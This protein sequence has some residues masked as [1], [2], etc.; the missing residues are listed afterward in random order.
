M[1][2]AHCAAPLGHRDVRPGRAPSAGAPERASKRSWFR[3]GPRR[4]RTPRAFPMAPGVTWRRS[5]PVVRQRGHAGFLILTSSGRRGSDA[6]ASAGREEPLI[7]LGFERTV[8]VRTPLEGP[9]GGPRERPRDVSSGHADV[10]RSHPPTCSRRPAEPTSATGEVLPRS[11]DGGGAREGGDI[12]SSHA[13]STVRTH[14]NGG[15]RSLR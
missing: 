4:Q 2:P 12:S 13:R 8:A 10:V 11:G 5:V 14:P 15:V 9:L 3:A 1:V 6:T 7:D